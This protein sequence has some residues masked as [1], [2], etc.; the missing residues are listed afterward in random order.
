LESLKKRETIFGVMQEA[1]RVQKKGRKKVEIEYNSALFALLRQKRKEM[2]DEAGVPPYVIFSDRTLTEM[3]AYYPQSGE[4]LLK[5]SGVGQAKLEKYGDAF[6]EV[7]KPY[8]DKHNIKESPRS[9]TSPP[10]AGRRARDEGELSPRS[11]IIAEAF[12]NG[13]TIQE[14]MVQYGF[15]ANTILDHLTKFIMAG[16]KLSNSES[17]QA[18]TSTTPDQQQTVFAAFDELSPTY[19]KPVFDKLNGTLSY[20]ELKTLRLLYLASQNE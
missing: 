3:A 8:C 12:N 13:T 17:L 9:S 18:F 2:A 10:P 15:V 19:L 1:E 5:I 4:S 6:L 11:R 7:I 20:D 16:N 14:L